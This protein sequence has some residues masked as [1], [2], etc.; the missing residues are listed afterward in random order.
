MKKLKRHL[1]LKVKLNEPTFDKVF[2]E[3]C[4]SW[5]QIDSLATVAG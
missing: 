4:R 5:E 1:F 3:S 2:N